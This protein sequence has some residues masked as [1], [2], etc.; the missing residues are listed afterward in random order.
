MCL[1]M[2]WICSVKKCDEVDMGDKEVGMCG[3]EV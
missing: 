2:K 1:V 3:E